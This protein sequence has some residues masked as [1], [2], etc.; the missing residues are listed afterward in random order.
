MTR[1]RKP[2]AGPSLLVTY[3][4]RCILLEQQNARL[5]NGS[6]HIE[7]EKEI[8]R[9]QQRCIDLEDRWSESESE[10]YAL[11]KLVGWRAAS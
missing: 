3:R 7:C 2:I 4:R 1:K 11:R 9:L 8:A 5:L 10:C 6:T